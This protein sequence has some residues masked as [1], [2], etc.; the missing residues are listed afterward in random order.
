MTRMEVSGMMGAGVLTGVQAAD[1]LGLCPRQ[2]RRLQRRY[3]MFGDVGLMDGRFGLSRKKRV[4]EAT[5][6]ELC[7]LKREVYPDFSL[8]HFHERV[9]E[10]HGFKVSYTFTRDVLQLRT[11]QSASDSREREPDDDRPALHL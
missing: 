5:I 9:V 6:E 11:S 4:P 8:R 3:E 7:R 10:K 2:L 1:I